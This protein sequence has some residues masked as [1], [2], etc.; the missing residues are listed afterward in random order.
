MPFLISKKKNL[1][2]SHLGSSA[3]KP[4]NLVMRDE[5]PFISQKRRGLGGVREGSG[6]G[7]SLI[8]LFSLP[9]RLRLVMM[10]N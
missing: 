6:D 3:K 1:S 4:W 2:I 8:F 10:G 9:V 7:V 5:H